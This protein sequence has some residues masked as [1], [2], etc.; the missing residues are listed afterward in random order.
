MKVILVGPLPPPYSG[1]EMVTQTLLETAKPLGQYI[2]VNISSPSNATKGHWSIAAL[3]RVL[4]QTSLFAWVLWTQR[5]Q[6]HIVHLPLSQSTTGTLRDVLFI[7][8]AK[9]FGY[10]VVGQFHGGDFLRFYWASRFQKLIARAL[11]QLDC[12][13][14]FDSSLFKQF[15]FVKREILQVLVNPV[16]MKWVKHWSSLRTVPRP[17]SRTLVILFMSHLSVAKGLVD[18]IEALSRLPSKEQWELNLAGEILDEERNVLWTG[19]D[20][21]KGWDKA[22]AIIH[23]HHLAERIHY[24]GVVTGEDKVRLFQHSHV[25]VLPSYSEGL[26]IVILEAMYAGLAVIASDV[27]AI[28]SVVPRSFLHK[29][30]DVNKLA[31]LLRE[32]T[33]E[34]AQ[35]IGQNNRQIVEQGY[36]PEQVM[37]QLQRIYHNVYPPRNYRSP[38]GLRVVRPHRMAPGKPFPRRS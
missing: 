20:M 13:L 21:N 29:P 36:L 37:S 26:P 25:L 32:M 35:N 33:V 3:W 9:G 2:H 11:A 16:P 34:K 24:H 17:S 30:G 28:S 10:L 12:L 38:K 1:P 6:S 7:R 14:V 8:L 18:L 31:D 22:Q 4:R 27:G 19:R 5:K 23:R 15:P